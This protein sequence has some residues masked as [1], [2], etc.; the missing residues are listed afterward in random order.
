MA[1]PEFNQSVSAYSSGTNVR[2][3]GVVI[4][5]LEVARRKAMTE[6]QRLIEAMEK[7]GISQDASAYSSG[8]PVSEIKK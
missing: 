3:I 2:E 4:D 1:N 6:D 8:T 5:I 7:W